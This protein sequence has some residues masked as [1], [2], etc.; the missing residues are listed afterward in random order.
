MKEYK[1]KTLQDI[2]DCV[3]DE[4]KERFIK[5]F[6]VFLESV[7]V[8][9]QLM[10][11]LPL[12]EEEKKI[13]CEFTWIDDEENKH[14]IVLIPKPCQVLNNTKD[15]NA[16]CRCEDCTPYLDNKCCGCKSNFKDKTK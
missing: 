8:L 14:E 2:L 5:D 11:M 7:I 16:H 15:C 4:N 12:P 9:K 6:S 13:E 1:I 10:E 3:T